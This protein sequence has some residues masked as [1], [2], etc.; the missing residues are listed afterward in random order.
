[1]P[2]PEEPKGHGDSEAHLWLPVL[3]PWRR[4]G[5]KP[6]RAPTAPWRG[7]RPLQGVCAQK[8]LP[9]L[10]CTRL[11][12]P[13]SRAAV[14]H[15]PARGRRPCPAGRPKGELGAAPAKGAPRLKTDLAGAR[16]QRKLCLCWP[17]GRERDTLLPVL[18]RKTGLTLHQFWGAQNDAQQEPY[19]RR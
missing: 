1:M 13:P 19:D 18:E 11:E 3:P 6:R 5:H 10:L 2:D 16:R 4:A 17:G 14:G 15:G 12:L 9:G 8:S 7:H